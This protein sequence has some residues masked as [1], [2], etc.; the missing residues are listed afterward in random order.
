MKQIFDDAG[1]EYLQLEFI[2]DFFVPE[3]DPLRAASDERRQLLFDAAAEFGAYHIKV[4]NIPGTPAEIPQLTEALRAS[5][6]R[7]RGAGR[8]RGHRLRVH[9]VRRERADAR[10]RARGGAGR[11]AA[12]RRPGDRHLAHGQARHRA[13]RA[14]QGAARV[15]DVGRAERRPV[16]EHGGRGR[17]G[18]QPPPPPGRGRV[19]DPRL[20]RGLPG[21]GLRPARGESRSCRRRCAS[22]R[23]KRNSSVSYE[24]TASQFS[25]AV[26]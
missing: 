20:H 23:S 3:G 21:R 5:C 13:R 4:G 25:P 18:R 12:E 2:A 16:G 7:T 6:A 19:P 8:R 17:R 11:R 1:L 15:P 9:A 22:S 26:A 24:T 14:A 10:H